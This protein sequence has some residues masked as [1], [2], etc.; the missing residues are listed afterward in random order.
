MPGWLPRQSPRL[1]RIV[2]DAQSRCCRVGIVSVCAFA[3]V[4]PFLMLISKGERTVVADAD[5]PVVT[6][7]QGPEK[8]RPTDEGGMQPLNQDVAIYDTLSGEAKS[9]TEVLLGQPENAHAPAAARQPRKPRRL[10][11]MHHRTRPA[12]LRRCRRRP[13]M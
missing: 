5:L 13:L 11:T 9:Q 3:I 6:A 10:S 1:W 7:E 12:I 4:M 2:P 8:V